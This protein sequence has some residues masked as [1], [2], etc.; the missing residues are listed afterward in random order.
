MSDFF[1][2]YGKEIFATLVPVIIWVLDVVFRARARLQVAE[3]HTFTFLVENPLHDDEGNL[4][5]NTQTVHTRSVTVQNS[6]RETATN[7]ELVFN[8]RPLCLNVWPSRAYETITAPDN[9]YI[10]KFSSLSP[11]ETLGCE[12]L[13]VN[14]DLPA[15]ITVRSDQCQ[16]KFVPM[17][18]QPVAS[19]AKR[20]VVGVLLFLGMATAVYLS[21][22]LVQF[23]VLQTPLGR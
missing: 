16:A 22:L 14:A 1:I 20:M 7:I 18:P 12:A 13:S 10:L 5:S 3:P 9:R 11:G 17:Y 19:R 2:Q 4:V 15:L 21:I 6:G 23:L 8:W